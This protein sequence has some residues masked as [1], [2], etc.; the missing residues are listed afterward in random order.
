MFYKDSNYEKSRIM[1][2]KNTEKFVSLM[3]SDVL[4]FATRA[5]ENKIRK[6]QPKVSFLALVIIFLAAENEN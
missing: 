5:E 2:A 4:K 6:E 3:E 1:P